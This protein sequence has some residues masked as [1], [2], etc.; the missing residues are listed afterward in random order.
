MAAVWSCAPRT[1]W[2]VSAGWLVSAD[3]LASVGWLVGRASG[4]DGAA[5][6]RFLEEMAEDGAARSLGLPA[7]ERTREA[8]L[9]LLEDEALERCRAVDR[10]RLLH[11]SIL[12]PDP[13]SKN[14]GRMKKGR[15]CLSRMLSRVSL[16]AYTAMV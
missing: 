2:L 10:R 11:A 16:R 8:R 7:A 6:D 9:Q 1:D 3:G 15:R 14:I 5:R 4:G 13:G 12:D